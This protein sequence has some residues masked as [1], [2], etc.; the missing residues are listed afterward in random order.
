MS[1][2]N[3]KSPADDFMVGKLVEVDTNNDVNDTLTGEIVRYDQH[4]PS[5]TIIRLIEDGRL[6]FGDEFPWSRVT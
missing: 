2:T 3:T 1:E 4:N 6:V 5:R